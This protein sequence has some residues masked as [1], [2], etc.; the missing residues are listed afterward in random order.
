MSRAKKA[1]A[2][3][4]PKEPFVVVSVEDERPAD[5][6]VCT[7]LRR[8]HRGSCMATLFGDATC[9]CT[10]FRKAVT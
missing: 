9:D 2:F 6:C 1:K 5:R 8:T 4:V 3:T 10:E 7:H